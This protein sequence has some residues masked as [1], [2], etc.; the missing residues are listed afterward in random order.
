[1]FNRSCLSLVNLK[2]GFELTLSCVSCT[3]AASQ[4]DPNTDSTR[5]R[6]QH[7]SRVSSAGRCCDS[8]R[9]ASSHAQFFIFF[10]CWCC[11]S[12][13]EFFLTSALLCRITALIPETDTS[14]GSGTSCKK[15]QAVGQK[16]ARLRGCAGAHKH[17]PAITQQFLRAQQNKAAR[18]RQLPKRR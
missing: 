2:L 3:A 18:S 5:F 13:A 8:E 16:R 4:T 6:C 12:L 7:R 11:L 9:P 17:K 1:M 10:C 14:A 15:Q